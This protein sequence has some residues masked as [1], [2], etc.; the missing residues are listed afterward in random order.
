MKPLLLAIACLL[1][2]N[3]GLAKEPA[4]DD[5]G[6]TDEVVEQ[7]VAY[8][9]VGDRE[10][11]YWLYRP[12]VMG[13]EP[14]GA[15]LFFH[16]GGWSGGNHKQFEPHAKHLAAKGLVVG[17]AEYRLTKRD[18]C[19]ASE[20]TADVWDAY[21]HFL[22]HANDYGFDPE[23]L[24]VGGGSAGGHLAA[25][26]GT[27]TYP[28]GAEKTDDPRPAAMF[29]FNPA[30]CL[31]PY[32]IPGAG[33]TD[34]PIGFE[35]GAI[36]AKVGC[37]P[38]KLSPLHHVD[39]KTPMAVLFHG[40]ADTTVGIESAELFCEAIRE[41]GKQSTL[42]TYPG[43][44]HSFFNRGKKRPDGANDYE[45]TLVKLDTALKGMGWIK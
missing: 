42:H 24:A 6:S 40:D 37:P 36:Q 41:Q 1:F 38:E 16:G 26:I 18:K 13:K 15:I 34:S 4:T 17:S 39:A 21:R 31:A 45:D 20:C 35:K 28:P 19:T 2:V 12:A 27:G 22:S 8:K 23:K 5:H 43:R 44:P 25:C 32:Q 3:T 9:T 30:V 11:Q 7:V 14:V 33:K 10:L 29:L